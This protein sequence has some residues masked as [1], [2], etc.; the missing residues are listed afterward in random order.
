MDPTKEWNN[1][2]NPLIQRCK[3]GPRDQTERSGQ[4]EKWTRTRD[5]YTRFKVS[6]FN[7]FPFPAHFRSGDQNRSFGSFQVPRRLLSI[8]S[9]V[10]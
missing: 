10:S 3:L 9:R 5:Q 2:T 7:L 1:N 4:S 6:Q 8:V